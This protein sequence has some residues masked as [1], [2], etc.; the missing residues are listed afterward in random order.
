ML[1]Q[2][3]L[4]MLI[5]SYQIRLIN[6]EQK[7][8]ANKQ[9]SRRDCLEISGIP[10]SVKDNELKTKILSI[11]EEIDAPVDPGLVEDCC[12]LPSKRNTKKLILKLNRRKDARKVLLN[13]KIKKLGSLNSEPAFWY[14]NL[15]K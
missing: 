8:F 9:Y 7:R 11:L 4:E 12:C 13:K 5:L 3:Y 2:T 14:K 15:H 1:I 6:A 10:P